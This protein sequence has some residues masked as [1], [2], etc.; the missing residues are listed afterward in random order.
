MG[1]HKPTPS[2]DAPP[3]LNP[4]DFVTPSE[5]VPLP[6]KGRYPEGHPL[7]GQDSIE[8]KYMTAK[9]EDILTNRS[10][11]K[12][13][14]AI[15]R[16]IQN[17]I[18]DSS[19]NARSLYIGDRNA[20]IIHA[21]ASA[22]GID[23]KTSIQCPACGEVSKFMFNL[24]EHEEYHGDNIEETEIKD[25]EDGTFSVELPLSTIVAT[26]RPLT[27]QDEVDL[28]S[29]GSSKDMTNDLITKQMKRFVVNFNGFDEKKIIN[30]VC[31]NMVAQD[32]R[33][34]R[35]CFR[36]ISPDIKMEQNF[37]CKHCEHEEVVVVPFGT[38][39]FWPDR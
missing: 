11:L 10:L 7:H 4:M 14:L 26:I 1:G 19:I 27:G 22:Y 38:D 20:I 25:N 6:S 39:F 35:D 5:F 30:H 31:D 2:E 17:I 37:T 9:D 28:L 32:A 13:G 12:K 21:R 15:D 29:E 18:K 24:G 33:Y 23:Y 8:I 36:L 3:M 34:L 16:L